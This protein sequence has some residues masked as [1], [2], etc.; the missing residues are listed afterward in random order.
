MK[1]LHLALLL[2]LF[3]ATVAFA[4]I[5]INTATKA[6]LTSLAGIG[7]AKA[8]AIIKH[9]KAKGPFKSLDELK[10]VEGIGE[11]IFAKIKADV[12]VGTAKSK[13]KTEAQPTK[14]STDKTAKKPVDKKVE[15]TAAE[16]NTPAKKKST[17]VE[18]KT[19]KKAAENKETS[20]KKK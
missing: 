1:N 13:A 15:K 4:G 5:D 20:D 7:P 14:K 18:K 10:N 6:E 3:L 17:S 2:V 11:K 8:E 19:E 12:T 9:R 16:K